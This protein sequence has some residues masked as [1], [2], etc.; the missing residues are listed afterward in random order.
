MSP[1]ITPQ[2]GRLPGQRAG[3]DHAEL[4]QVVGLTKH[5]AVTAGAVFRRTVAQIHAVDDVS[6]VLDEGMTL[7]LVGES[8]CGKSTVAR[9]ILRLVRPTAGQVI[10]RGHDLATAGPASLRALRRDMQIV[11]QDPY[12]SLNPRLTVAQ[13]VSEPLRVHGIRGRTNRIAQLLEEVGLAT[14]DAGRYPH[15]F[16]GGQRQRIAIARALATRPKLVFCDEPTSALDVSIQGQVLNLLADLQRELGLSYVL[17]SHDLSVLRD[18]TDQVAVMYLGKIVEFA[19]TAQLYD[20]PMH[21]YTVALLSAVP[22]P[23]PAREDARERVTLRG[24]VPSPTEPPPA[25]RFHT[26][27][28]KA[29]PICRTSEPPLLELHAGHWV[30]CHFPERTQ[31]KPL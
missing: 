27:C 6:F 26:R 25:C 8:G 24:Q 4:L 31:P 28:W 3:G 7:G 18:V 30:A 21:P 14:E 17:I 1:P 5:F 22:V 2:P 29:Q 13:I 19:D 12:A 20:Q 15:E 23:D 11:F 9:S 16:S 10:F